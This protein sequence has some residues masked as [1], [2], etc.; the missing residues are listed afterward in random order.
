MVPEQGRAALWVRSVEP[1][2]SKLSPSKE[3]K[4]K[5]KQNAP[6][7]GLSSKQIERRVT[8]GQRPCTKENSV[9]CEQ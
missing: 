4:Q 8:D 1:Q 5:T 2:G 9:I 6:R 7:L 3:A